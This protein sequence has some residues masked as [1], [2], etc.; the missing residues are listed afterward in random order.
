MS[1]LIFLLAIA[2]VVY[3][4]FKTVRRPP[5]PSVAEKPI[6]NM[7]RC[8]QCG[9]NVPK[10]ESLQVGVYYFCRAEHRDAY[11]G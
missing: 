2:L 11:R 3:L 4:I 9:V 1:R 7:V 6:E 8:A 10:S 5:P